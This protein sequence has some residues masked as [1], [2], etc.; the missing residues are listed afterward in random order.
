MEI[1]RWSR[2]HYT[3]PNTRS[4]YA[5]NNTPAKVSYVTR[6]KRDELT[7]EA[8]RRF[9]VA[10]GSRFVVKRGY[11]GIV[12]VDNYQLDRLE[13]CHEVF[14]PVDISAALASMGARERAVLYAALAKNALM[15][16]VETTGEH[17]VIKISDGD[18]YALLDLADMKWVG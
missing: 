13:K 17:E 9:F 6:A 12:T 11:T 3:R 14:E 8:E 1:Y 16:Q 10:L 2:T 7:G 4:K 5:R 15:H 18:S